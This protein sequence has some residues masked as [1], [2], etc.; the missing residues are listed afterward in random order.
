[1]ARC[2]HATWK[3]IKH[4]FVKGKMV[5]PIRGLVLHLT[6][7]RD[8]TLPSLHGFFDNPHQEGKKRSAH[9]G[10][11][12]DGEMWQFVDTDDVA[13]AVDGVWGGDG[14]D[15]HWVSV[16]NSGKF[17]DLLTQKQIGTVANLF[18]W[19]HETFGVPFALA[20]KKGDR[21]LG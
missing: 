10:V 1:M 17:P 4:H 12:R 21:G 5:Q 13:F 20:E 9:F 8:Q 2:P 16:E 15:N 3:P 6:D 19:L 14:V 11:S 18:F 7:V